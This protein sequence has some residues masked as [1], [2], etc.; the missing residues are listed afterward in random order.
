MD[1]IRTVAT[2]VA[3]VLVGG[4]AVYFSP[5]EG[6]DALSAGAGM[7]TA[8]MAHPVDGALLPDGSKP[9]L[10][11]LPGTAGAPDAGGTATASGGPPGGAPGA[12]GPD[13]KP[14]A[15]PAG[16]PPNGAIADGTQGTPAQPGAAA[17]PPGVA[18]LPDP[19]AM[20][21]QNAGALTTVGQTTPPPTAT[22][23]GPPLD[24]S[25]ATPAGPAPVGGNRLEKHLRNAPTLWANV[26]AATQSSSDKNVRALSADVQAH[27]DALPQIG[28]RMPPLQ[29][30]ASYL[31]SSRVLLDRLAA[32]GVDVSELSLQID[33]LMRPPRGKIPGGPRGDGSSG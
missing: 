28:D 8:D 4:G 27:I 23:E 12:I 16:A 15:P 19:S 21:G 22:P 11:P 25:P 6:S 13:G 5:P 18:T 29:E 26:L 3:G 20:A 1:R 10:P 17:M 30:I 7:P 9:P 24:T 31:A 2:F 32:A 14:M 33:V